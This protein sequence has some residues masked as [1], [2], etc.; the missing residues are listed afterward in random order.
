MLIKERPQ[1]TTALQK[2][3]TF[4]DTATR[5]VN[6]RRHDLVNNLKNLEPTIKALA[7]V[8]PDLDPGA[9]LRDRRS[10]TA[11]TSSTGR[12]AATTSTCSPSFDLT[13]LRG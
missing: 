13:V 1:L 3:G 10:R 2:L 9:G 11:R 6:D 4:S 5:L 8:G 12:S 7:D